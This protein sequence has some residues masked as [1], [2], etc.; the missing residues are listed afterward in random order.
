MHPDAPPGG[1]TDA[2]V[3]EERIS[4]DDCLRTFT[5]GSAYAEFAEKEKGRIAAGQLADIVVLS[6]DITK[7]PAEQILRAK[8]LKTFTGGRLVYEQ[9]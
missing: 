6:A 3:P 2:W 4:L 8:V 5:Q 1:P 9:K 7:V